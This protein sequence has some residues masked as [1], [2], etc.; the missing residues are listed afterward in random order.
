MDH[1]TLQQLADL[2]FYLDALPDSLPA[3][4][5]SYNFVYYQPSPEDIKV[6]GGY[7]SAVNNDLEGVFCPKAG[8]A[9]RVSEY[10]RSADGSNTRGCRGS[11]DRRSTDL[12][13]PAASPTSWAAW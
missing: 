1:T 3:S 4:N 13:V 10:V 9:G 8:Y 6:Y 7:D 2:R 12:V 5:L 11:G